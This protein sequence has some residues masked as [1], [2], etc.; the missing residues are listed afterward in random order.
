M[1]YVLSK[2]DQPLYK[3]TVAEICKVAKFE[4]CYYY[5][6]VGAGGVSHIAMLIVHRELGVLRNNISTLANG[7]TTAIQAA[8]N[9]F[10]SVC[11]ANIIATAASQIPINTMVKEVL[12]ARFT[13]DKTD[14]FMNL[15]MAA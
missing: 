12:R 3:I 9:K 15:A 13:A 14:S 2:S 6:L 5:R 1:E 8:V 7:N 4:R 10:Y 11:N